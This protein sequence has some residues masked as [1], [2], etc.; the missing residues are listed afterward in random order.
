M[1]KQPLLVSVLIC[2]LNGKHSLTLTLESLFTAI[3]KFEFFEVVVV[4]DGSDAETKNLLI[5]YEPRIKIVTHQSNF[6]R[7]AAR[8]SALNAANGEFVA[9]IDD[10]IIVPAEWATNLVKNLKA[11]EFEAKKGVG[12]P[13]NVERDNSVINWYLQ[14][15]NPFFVFERL[16]S[17]LSLLERFKRL[18][19]AQRTRSEISII[20][21]NLLGGNMIFRKLDLDRI[22]GFNRA[23]RHGEDDDLC[24]RLKAEFGNDCLVCFDNLAVSH[25]VDE[26]F[27]QFSER[28]LRYAKS[29]G[30]KFKQ[31]GGI[32][33]VNVSIFTVLLS[34]VAISGLAAVNCW[35]AVFLGPLTPLLATPG[36]F[37]FAAKERNLKALA[38]PF[39]SFFNGLV[40][41]VGF[42]A[43]FTERSVK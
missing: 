13:C 4:D 39:I 26:N 37:R 34:F 7:G 29:A 6:G 22:G 8:Q 30:Q 18:I 23:L 38:I 16:S 17:G 41:F 35:L 14:F 33:N 3:S 24:T 40:F 43:G 32:P 36:W 5:S 12:G 20:A 10:D 9:Y 31:N 15:R 19:H 11:F 2:T 25:F 28:N 21:E 1:P 27:K 42:F